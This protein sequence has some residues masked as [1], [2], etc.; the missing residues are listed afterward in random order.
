MPFWERLTERMRGAVNLGIL[1][2]LT[3]GSESRERFL[4][5]AR[6]FV[7]YVVAEHDGQLFVLATDDPT[8]GKQFTRQKLKEQAVLQR[9]LTALERSGIEVRRRTF[10]DVG[11]N[12]GTTTLAALEAG[13]VRVVAC[14]PLPRNVR[15][16]R[17]NLVLNGLED[18]V[19]PLELAMSNRAG[20]GTIDTLGGS[21][22]ARVLQPAELPRGQ[23]EEIRLGRLDDLIDQGVV[24]PDEVGFLFV[25]AEGHERQVLEGASR[26][27]RLD[28]PLVMEVN[29]KLL[30]LGGG[31]D[32]LSDVL[33][34][35]YTHI[36][37]LRSKGEP[38]FAPVE[39]LETMIEEGKG[40]DILACRLPRASHAAAGTRARAAPRAAAR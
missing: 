9:A 30:H 23:T 24:G 37:D 36:L 34:L 32:G 17:A 29:P 13:F 25:D 8:H 19:T 27:L 31:T 16:L 10:V 18:L 7:P 26:L 12:I 6:D 28:I 38:A 40:T 11:A 4:R 14:E 35:S 33:A 20:S 3:N 22:K 5:V 21:R 2:R 39:S 15:I 1:D